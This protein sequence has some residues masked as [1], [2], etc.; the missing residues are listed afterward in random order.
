MREENV[1]SP[2]RAEAS[3]NE[4]SELP[5]P[6]PK[7]ERPRAKHLTDSIPKIRLRLPEE[8]YEI[9]KTPDFETKYEATYGEY[10]PDAI[11]DEWESVQV[12]RFK[13]ENREKSHPPLHFE[14]HTV[15]QAREADPLFKK[16]LPRIKNADGK[17]RMDLGHPIFTTWDF[18]YP[19][20]WNQSPISDADGA[21]FTR[22]ALL[23]YAPAPV[24]AG[25]VR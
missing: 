4:S 11:L 22:K 24:V 18:K 2:S 16:A 19:D 1:A 5:R 15:E 17:Y 12:R 21:C 9:Q 7:T 13:I 20:N 14:P 6:Q 10:P 3:D 25:K 23:V 8:F